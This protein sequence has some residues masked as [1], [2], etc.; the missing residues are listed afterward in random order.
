MVS[1]L[2]RNQL[3][4]DAD[5]ASLSVSSRVRAT[6]NAEESKNQWFL[7]PIADLLFC[8]GGLVWIFFFVDILL[9]WRFASAWSQAFAIFV[10]FSSHLFGE[11]HV[12]ATL[13]KIFQSRETRAEFRFCTQ[14]QPFFWLLGAVICLANQA[15]LVVL[16][17][18][19]FLWIYQHFVG[20]AYGLILVYCSKN[21]YFFNCLEKSILQ[22]VLYMAAIVAITQQLSANANDQ[23]D[24][25]GLELPSWNVLPATAH[26]LLIQLMQ[27]LLVLFTCVIARKAIQEAKI[28]P[29]PA[30][31]MLTTIIVSFI[32]IGEVHNTLWL[33]LPAF[34]HSTQY[35]VL[36]ATQYLKETAPSPLPAGKPS[37]AQI[38]LRAFKYYRNLMLLAVGLYVLLPHLMQFVGVK[39]ELAFAT[40]FVVLNL[41]HFVTDMLVWR[42]RKIS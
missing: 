26:L 20:Q 8:C 17:K 24:F 18:L 34:F 12:S 32:A 41:H 28:F 35:L 11:A 19:Y 16:L 6:L 14:I 15:V 3:Q 4:T 31:L 27:I 5:K 13:L 25:L 36:T 42:K 9:S 2:K 37:L 7:N 33:L 38:G 10:V 21:R 40:V 30:A 39:F 29:L 23:N 22:I 1:W